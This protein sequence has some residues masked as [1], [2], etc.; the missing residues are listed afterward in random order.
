MMTIFK[1]FFGIIGA[2]ILLYVLIVVVRTV[3]SAGVNTVTATSTAS[4]APIGGVI[5]STTQSV[6]SSVAAFS[7]QNWLANFHPFTFAPLYVTTNNTVSTT[8]NSSHFFPTTVETPQA[9]LYYQNLNE[10]PND[11]P[12]DYI[13]QGS[14]DYFSNQNNNANNNYII[15]NL[16]NGNVIRNFQDISGTA[17]YEVFQN[18]VFYGTVYDAA[19]NSLGTVKFF[20]NGELQNNGF[21]RFRGVLNYFRPATQTGKIVFA[22]GGS[23]PVVFADFRVNRA[24]PRMIYPSRY[25]QN[26]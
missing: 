20:Q 7:F 11:H 5:S 10:A 19:G 8:S 4:T 24:V 14:S 9:K 21:A 22:N 17:Y 23:I 2:I 25:I 26:Y 18:N 3:I 12:T 16:G 15:P 1:Y 6:A 13:P